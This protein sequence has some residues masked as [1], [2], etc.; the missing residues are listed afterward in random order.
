M[1][2]YVEIKYR[3]HTEVYIRDLHHR[4]PQ[5]RGGVDRVETE[6]RCVTDWYHGP[7]AIRSWTHGNVSSTYRLKR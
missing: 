3:L 2:V 7:Q 1:C 4:G 6:P 5:A